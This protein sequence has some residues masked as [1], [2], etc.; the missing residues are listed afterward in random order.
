MKIFEYKDEHLGKSYI[1]ISKIRELTK[2]LG[3]IVI[4]FDNG[5]K[6]VVSVDNPDET[7]AALL[8]ALREG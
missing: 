1:V 4:T 2:A 7:L 3:E 8:K 5:D 6:R